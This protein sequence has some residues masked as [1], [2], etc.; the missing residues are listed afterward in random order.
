MNIL[1]Y[2]SCRCVILIGIII[3]TFIHIHHG[4]INALKTYLHTF[5]YFLTLVQ[6]CK[7]IVHNIH[8]SSG[9]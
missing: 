8:I 9:V 6:S 2:M 7:A 4:C 3:N 5:D 1:H